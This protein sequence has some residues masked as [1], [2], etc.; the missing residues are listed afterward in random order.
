[1]LVPRPSL[2]IP[3]IL[4][5]QSYSDLFG[6]PEHGALHEGDLSA[7]PES[8]TPREDP[9]AGGMKRSRTLPPNNRGGRERTKVLR[10]QKRSSSSQPKQS[11][12]ESGS[13][14]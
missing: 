6:R 7:V 4:T 3:R 14:G 13:G 2:S 8:P 9:V 12:N 11:T 10:K 5:D 1:V